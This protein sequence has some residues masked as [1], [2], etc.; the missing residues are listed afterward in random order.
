MDM[1]EDDALSNLGKKENIYGRK[2]IW[3][4]MVGQ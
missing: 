2:Y 4:D 3:K 1:E